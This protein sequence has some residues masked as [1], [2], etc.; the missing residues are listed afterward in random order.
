MLRR[1]SGL[2]QSRSLSTSAGRPYVHKVICAAFI[3][4]GLLL[5]A[6]AAHAADAATC[7]AY[8]K[9]ATAKAEGVRSYHC[10]FDLNDPRWTTGRSGHAAWCKSADKE[11][12][13]RENAHRRGE[14]KVCQTCRAYAELGA[15]AA[16]D[17]ARLKCG[18]KGPRWNAKA[19]DHFGWCMEHRGRIATDE[20]DMAAA[21]K[22]TIAKM[23]QPLGAE[24]GARA[25]ETMACRS[26]KPKARQTS[27][28]KRPE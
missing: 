23:Q 24:T 21:Y 22:A 10:G 13:A 18:Y 5:Q 28:Q 4:M 12:V 11:T 6:G 7:D 20:N 3:A 25:H 14:I 27:G 9:E 19:E 1:R 17:N 8:V 2:R 26:R 15:A 16:A